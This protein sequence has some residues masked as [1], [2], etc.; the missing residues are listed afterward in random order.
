MSRI[1]K[2]TITFILSIILFILIG[3]TM[4][5]QS[6]KTLITTENLSNYVKSVDILNVDLG[7]IFNLEEKGITLEEEIYS[8]AIYN[9]I[10]EPIINDILKSDEIN[11]I[12]GG[13]FKSVIEYVLKGDTKPE[14]KEDTIQKML[15]VAFVSLEDHMNIMLDE[16][17][18][19]IY[20]RKYCEELT[21]IVPERNLIIKDYTIDK[22]NKIIYFDIINLFILI[23]VT[24]LLI[25]IVNK[26]IYKLFRYLGTVMIINGVI[27][28]I[29]GCLN[30]LMTTLL[31]NKFMALQNFIFPLITNVLTIIFKNGVLVSFTGIFVYL[32]YVIANRIKLNNKINELLSK[33]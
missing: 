9:D 22:A 29:I 8:L 23:I 17:E 5:I 11:N 30:D 19:E 27:F 32:I 3:V 4:F 1:L 12:L 20:I 24:C 13:F 26:S 31:S 28:V 7:I 10:P 14:I 2:K 33:Q 16:E 6:S 15:D 25:C 18:L 21:D